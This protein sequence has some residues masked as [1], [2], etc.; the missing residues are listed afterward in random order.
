MSLLIDSVAVRPERFRESLEPIGEHGVRA[1]SGAART[2]I[3]KYARVWSVTSAPLSTSE[4]NALMAKLEVIGAHNVTGTLID[5]TVSCLFTDISRTP[6][7]NADD[8]VIS[9]RM[10]EVSP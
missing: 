8:W 1:F 10:M 9:F 2:A 7:P 6:M 3:R 5:G 4:A